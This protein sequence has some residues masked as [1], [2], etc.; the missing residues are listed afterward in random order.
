MQRIRGGKS[1]IGFGR[2]S[3]KAQTSFE[4]TY[5]LEEILEIFFLSHQDCTRNMNRYHICV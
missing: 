5:I 2:I 3:V 1:K 4:A